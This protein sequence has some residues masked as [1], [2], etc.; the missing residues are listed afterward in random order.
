MI[1]CIS[2]FI[3][4]ASKPPAMDIPRSS[5]MYQPTITEQERRLNEA[6]IKLQRK[7]EMLRAQQQKMEQE[8]E[9]ELV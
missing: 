7:Q 2:I 3:N 4:L 6:K 5:S 8:I 9:N 1:Y